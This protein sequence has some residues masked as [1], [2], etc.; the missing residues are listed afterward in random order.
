MMTGRRQR[1]AEQIEALYSEKIETREGSRS[2]GRNQENESETDDATEHRSSTES[3][4][5]ANGSSNAESERE[6]EEQPAASSPGGSGRAGEPKKKRSRSSYLNTKSGLEWSLNAPDVKHSITSN[7]NHTPSTKGAAADASTPLEAW[8]CLFTNDI[9]DIILLHTNE[10]IEREINDCKM[11]NIEL[12]STHRKTDLLELKAFIG[13]LYYA[14]AQK[15]TKLNSQDKWGPHSFPLFKATMCRNRFLFLQS[16][17]RFDDKGTRAE[18]KKYDRFTHIREIWELFIKNCTDNYEPGQ[19]CTIDEQLF[20]FRGR[21]IFKVYLPAKPD[22]YSIKIV[23]LNDSVTHYMIN[24]MP[25]VGTVAKEPT[26]TVPDYYVRKLSE[27]LYGS[28]RNITCDNWF[29]SVPICDKLKK[30]Y[31]LTLVGTIKKSKREIPTQF[32]QV[33]KN[34]SNVQFA[35]ADGKVLVSLNPKNKKIV[36]L[37]SSL[38]TNGQID[39]ETGM[40]EIV[41]FYHKSKDATDSYDKKCHH[42]S[43]TMRTFRWILRMFF[44][45]L[46]QAGVNCFILYS[47]NSDNAALNRHDFLV[48]LS[49]ELIKPYLLQRRARPSL[50]RNITT[51]IGEFLDNKEIPEDQDIR[52]YIGENKLDKP[53]RCG[54]CHASSDR[55]TN[56]KCL[57][58][59]LPMCKEHTA[60]ICVVCSINE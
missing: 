44:A 15:V 53:K 58:C 50:R 24:A 60:K 1:Q 26:E 35:Y 38:H 48:Q 40:P 52:Y 51:L 5:D 49:M 20:S 4:T 19:N 8:S 14:G 21:C 54:L 39:A 31:N 34:G 33:P 25:C 46:D 23:S 22:K 17:L 29:T 27:S 2:R 42:Y 3:E 45:M 57:K 56:Y 11:A 55:K 37:L 36:L 10:Q 28:G 32:K 30:D 6:D 47:L 12:Q 59:D 13:L 9:L 18:R 41:V 7:T 16:C 43:V